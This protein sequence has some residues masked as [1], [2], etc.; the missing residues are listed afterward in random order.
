[1][2]TEPVPESIDNNQLG[3]ADDALTTARRIASTWLSRGPGLGLS[4]GQITDALLRRDPDDPNYI[5]LA[6]FEKRW[7]LF[8][9]RL[10]LR[11]MD[12]TPA[13]D[14]AH[15]RGASWA[16]IGGVLGI[17]RATAYNRFSDKMGQ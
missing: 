2:F 13:V 15:V 14:D 4:A 10:L 3:I 1:V 9:L 8:V 11:V 12:P 16:D 5:R 6:P 7:A 17:A